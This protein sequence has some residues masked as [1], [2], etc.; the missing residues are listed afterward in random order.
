MLLQNL[1]LSLGGSD[2]HNNKVR[3]WKKIQESQKFKTGY[4]S[5]NA[6]AELHYS[7]IDIFKRASIYWNYIL[8]RR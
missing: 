4:S 6:V 3:N 2:Y 5:K 1:R 7:I 8:Y